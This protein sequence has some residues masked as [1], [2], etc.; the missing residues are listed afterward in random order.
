[1]N[2]QAGYIIDG[3]SDVINREISNKGFFTTKQ[4]NIKVNAL[5]GL[6]ENASTFTIN[7][8]EVES[9]NYLEINPVLAVQS[10]IL[11][12]GLPTR[13]PLRIEKIFKKIGLTSKD[14]DKQYEEKFILN[15]SKLSFEDYFELLHIIKPNLDISRENYS[16]NLDSHLEWRFLENS[17]PVFKQILQSQREFETLVTN[18]GGK[19]RLDF[20]F[21]K[22]YK[23]YNGLNQKF[24]YQTLVFEVDGPHHLLKEHI[25]YDKLRDEN[26]KEANGNVIRFSHFDISNFSKSASEYLQEDILKIH[27]KNFDRDIKEDLGKYT[28]A[29]LPFSVARIQKTLVEIFIRKPEFL[30]KEILNICVIERDIPG[31]AIAVEIFKDFISNINPLL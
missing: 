30:Q 18:F 29:L 27:T 31:S 15:E 6:L 23:T 8:K 17:N 14:L 26:I 22:P 21:T 24:E 2:F 4:N 16:G 10:N 13:A 19:R 28:L 25:I 9:I 20:S 1:M 11:S 5:Q 12:R 7:F 3:V